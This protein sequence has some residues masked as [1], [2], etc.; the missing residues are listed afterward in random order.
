MSFYD[1]VNGLRVEAVKATLARPQSNGRSVLDIALECGFGS[2]S[3]FNAAFRKATGM[4]PSAYR[5][6][7]A[8]RPPAS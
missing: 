6:T 3:T 7:A 4:A 8:G 5:L 2:K 1:Y